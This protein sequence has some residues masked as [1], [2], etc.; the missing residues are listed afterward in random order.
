MNKDRPLNTIYIHTSSGKKYYPF[1]PN[2]DHV[3]IE[4]IAHHLAT[5]ARW[6]GATQHKSY[7]DRILYSVAEHSVYVSLYV[8]S[9]LRRPDLAL[10]AL[11]HDGSEAFN[12]DLIRPLK[13]SSAFAEP[14]KKV[15]LINEAAVAKRFQLPLEMSPEVKIAD[16]AVCAA[17]AIQIVPKHSSEEWK[18][19]RQYD[20]KLV[21]PFEIEML[22]PYEAK[23]LF[24]THY[25]RL[26][27][28]RKAAA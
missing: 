18:S 6:N 11:L 19:G 28:N 14:F 23:K 21:A 15:E 25:E 10:E 9:V 3:D 16:E 20:D 8:E 7:P 27:L 13:Y 24:L 26:T 1:D 12:G 22:L 4:V 17:E 5:R 2:P